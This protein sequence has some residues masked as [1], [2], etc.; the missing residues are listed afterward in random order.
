MARRKGGVTDKVLCML[1]VA[2]CL[3]GITLPR[4]AQLSVASWAPFAA[5]GVARQ[6]L[7]LPDSLMRALQQAGLR[8]H[9]LC[10]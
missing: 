3:A 1:C 6:G 10:P 7:Q 2:H 9:S 5:D 8:W 4:H